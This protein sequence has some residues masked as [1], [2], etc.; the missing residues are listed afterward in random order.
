MFGVTHPKLM[1]PRRTF[2]YMLYKLMCMRAANCVCELRPALNV[3]ILASI[4]N[5]PLEL[6]AK[7]YPNC[8]SVVKEAVYHQHVGEPSWLIP[9]REYASPENYFRGTSCLVQK[10]GPAVSEL[11]F[12]VDS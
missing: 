2:K 1:G 12:I 7:S 9:G 10:F 11:I 5:S 8:L 6:C 4:N 3:P